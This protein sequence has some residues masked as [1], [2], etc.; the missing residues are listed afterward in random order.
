MTKLPDRFKIINGAIKKDHIVR[1]Y[2][3]LTKKIVWVKQSYSDCD[4]VLK[5]YEMIHRIDSP[6]VVSATHC[7]AFEE[8]MY[9]VLEDAGAYNLRRKL[10][11][12]PGKSRLFELSK[13]IASAICAVEHARIHYRDLM[14]DHIIV[15]NKEKP[16][17]A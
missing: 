7:I 8:G 16:P 15:N 3:N 1:A 10:I 17:S 14:D 9:L 11:N 4:S 6:F 12:N 13:Q 2:D 5:E